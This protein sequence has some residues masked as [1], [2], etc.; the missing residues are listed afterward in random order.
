MFAQRS[1][2]FYQDKR[3]HPSEARAA[4]RLKRSTMHATVP[5]VLLLAEA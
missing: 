5:T 2:T 3:R 4:P 1:Q